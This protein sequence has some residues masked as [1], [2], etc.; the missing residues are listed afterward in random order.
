MREQKNAS[1]ITAQI[2][3]AVLRSMLSQSLIFVRFAR[4]SSDDMA[5]LRVYGP[6]ACACS[7]MK[8][9]WHLSHLPSGLCY[10]Y[11]D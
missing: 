3:R 11:V 5:S 10:S 6:V 2:D 7:V 4:H 9:A 1:V 8:I